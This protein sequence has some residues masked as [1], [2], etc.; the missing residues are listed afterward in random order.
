[1]TNL[2]LESYLCPWRSAGGRPN[3]RLLLRQWFPR[4]SVRPP[5]SLHRRCPR[6]RSQSQTYWDFGRDG[7]SSAGEWKG[8]RGHWQ[9]HWLTMGLRNALR[10]RLVDVNC[11]SV[12]GI[13]VTNQRLSKVMM[14][15]VAKSLTLLLIFMFK[16]HWRTLKGHWRRRGR[17][18]RWRSRDREVTWFWFHICNKLRFVRNL[19][20]SCGKLNNCL[21]KVFQC[22]AIFV[23]K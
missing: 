2:R 6:P 3:P 18:E 13:K 1:M 11:V 20:V 14:E 23:F 7:Q 5:A 17:R 12:P 19:I 8:T 16:G 4:G 15:V 9:S 22:K 10:L 21:S